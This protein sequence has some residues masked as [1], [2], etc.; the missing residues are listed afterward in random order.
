[1]T[2]RI[3]EGDVGIVDTLGNPLSTISGTNGEKLEVAS[4]I[5]ATISDGAVKTVEQNLDSEGY[6]KNS[7]HNMG[8]YNNQWEPFSLDARCCQ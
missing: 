4:N 7:S 3:I 8:Q 1:M 5:D 6:I 2:F